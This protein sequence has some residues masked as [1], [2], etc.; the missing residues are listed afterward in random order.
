MKHPSELEMSGYNE[1]QS[2][3][4]RYALIDQKGLL[5]FCE[6][7]DKEQLRIEHRQWI[8]GALRKRK[9]DA[10]RIG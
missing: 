2:P 8:E 3:P 9:A 4:E 6:I 5:E 1:I 10:R 7:R